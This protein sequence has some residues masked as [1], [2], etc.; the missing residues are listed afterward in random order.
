MRL[1]HVTLSRVID[2]SNIVVR[3]KNYKLH[4][5]LSDDN[6]NF[7]NDSTTTI[8]CQDPSIFVEKNFGQII[9]GI[10]YVPVSMETEEASRTDYANSGSDASKSGVVNKAQADVDNHITLYVSLPAGDTG[11]YLKLGYS[12][13]EVIS[14]ESLGTGSD[15]GNDDVGGGALSTDSPDIPDFPNYARQN[16]PPRAQNPG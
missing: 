11:A 10:D 5:S 6:S 7:E 4:T 15:Y 1:D 12:I 9:V 14:K 16:G 2:L 8:L 3:I 13:M